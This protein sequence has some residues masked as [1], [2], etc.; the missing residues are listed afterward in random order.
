MYREDPGQTREPPETHQVIEGSH[1]NEESVCQM[2]KRKAEGARKEV[3]DIVVEARRRK[4]L[5]QVENAD[6]G[7]GNCWQLLRWVDSL[8]E[9]HTH[10]R[11]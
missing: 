6:P 8:S 2:E 4:I 5:K 3:T 11:G 10:G 7:T 9:R 1:Q